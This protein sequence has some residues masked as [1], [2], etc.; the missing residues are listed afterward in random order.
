MENS[1]Y[2]RI[3]DFLTAES[4]A[5][6]VHQ[7]D[8][9]AVRFWDKWLLDHPEQSELLADAAAIIRGIPFSPTYIGA[10]K[11]QEEWNTL[12]LRVD[13][14]SENEPKT[15]LLMIPRTYRNLALRMVAGLGILFLMAFAWQ[16]W[17]SPAVVSQYVDFGERMEMDLPDGTRVA[18]NA[19]ST[20]RY[21]KEKPRKV[22]LDGEA[23]F[24][25][26]EKP[27]SGERFQ[28]I[29]PDLTV[30]VY[31]TEFNVN[32]RKQQT[33]VVLE[34]GKVRLAFQNGTEKEMEPGDLI[35]YSAAK[36]E[37]LEETRLERAETLTSW[38]DGTLIFDN[39]SLK[40]GMARIAEL[41]GL[42]VV[43][44]NTEI[45]GK[46]I[47]LAVPTENLAI[48]IKAMERSGNLQIS[49]IDNQLIIDNNT[50]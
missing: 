50:R 4:F 42:E 38:K 26:A 46:L 49:R 43:F 10:E 33:Q 13:E 11:G 45:A 35:I 8:P 3:E 20:L 22:W 2:R 1:D 21:H 34:T 44:K 48:C 27:N 41:Y 37:V 7:C 32:S 47:H 36:N 23:F 12:N 5:A 24:W 40:E 17:R 29:T 14:A 15:T 28:V 6:W 25:V 18:L 39:I 31:G 16:Q 9:A 30:E 19:N